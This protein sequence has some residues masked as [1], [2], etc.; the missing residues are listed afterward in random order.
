MPVLDLTPSMIGAMT[1]IL[2]VQVSPMRA[3]PHVEPRTRTAL[4][5][6]GMVQEVGHG[7]SIA[8]E[9]TTEGVDA[10]RAVGAQGA[11]LV[12]QD[13]LRAFDAEASAKTLL[14]AL[15]QVAPQTI[16]RLDGTDAWPSWVI[17]GQSGSVGWYRSKS[18]S[19]R[20]NKIKSD[21][22]Q[23]HK[24]LPTLIER[25]ESNLAQAKVF[26][27]ELEAVRALLEA[28]QA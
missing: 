2:K 23:V 5:K 28:P 11:D 1:N 3:G 6:R 20:L 16:S 19:G 15:Q 21:L 27:A 7:L 13:A 9:L 18:A 14:V 4:L 26:A 8:I 10:L 25:M 12:L 24:A 22:D 17:T